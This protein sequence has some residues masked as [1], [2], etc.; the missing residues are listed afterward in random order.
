MLSTALNFPI[1]EAGHA[2]KRGAFKTRPD[3][4]QSSHGRV[5]RGSTAKNVRNSEM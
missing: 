5:G 3:T 2:Y 4:R 1:S